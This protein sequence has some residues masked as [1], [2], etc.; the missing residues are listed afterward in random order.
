MYRIPRAELRA[1]LPLMLLSTTA[2]LA[3]SAPPDTVALEQITVAGERRGAAFG[4]NGGRMPNDPFVQGYTPK[5]TTTALKIPA[6]IQDIPVSVQ[7]V[8]QELIQD[9]GALTVRQAIDTVS[10]VTSSNAIPGSQSFRIR[11]FN[12]GFSNLR[13]GFRETSN[14]QDVQGIER[15]EVLK[16]PASVLYGGN[17]AAGGVVNIVT[18]TPVDLNFANAALTGGSF[19]LVRPTF[20]VNQDLTGDGRLAMRVTGAFERTDTYRDFAYGDSKFVNPSLRWR[21]T[22]QDEIIVRAQVL[23]SNFSYGPYQSPLS[24]TTLRLPYSFSFS[25]PN[26][27]D[28]HRNAER[29]SYDWI[30][31]FDDT[32]RFRSGFNA[33]AVNYDIGTDRFAVLRFNADG[34]TVSRTFVTGPQHLRDYDWQNEFSGTF[35]TGDIRHDWLAG[36]ETY[37]SFNSATSFQGTLPNL[38]IFAPVYGVTPSA[39]RLSASSDASFTNIA[40]YVQDFVTLTPQ[41]RLLLGG[42][43]DVTDTV[44]LNRL[45]NRTSANAADRFSPRLGITYEPVPTTALFANWANGFVPTTQ[46]TVSGATLPPSASE[47]FEVGV[48]Q[49]A[50]DGRVQATVALF[51]VTRTNV[52]TPDPTNA[53]FSIA[54]GEQQSRGVEVDIAG[55]I[56]PGWKGVAS[57]AYTFADVTKDNRLPVGDLLAGVARHAGQVWTTYEFLP[58]S[59]LDGFGIGAGV[60]AE[61]AREATLPNTFKLPGYVRL[62]AAAWYRFAIQGQPFRAQL[63]LQNITDRR[64]YDTDGANVLRPTVPFTVLASISTQF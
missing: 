45:T 1:A 30:H 25:D 17:L 27:R 37:W 38:N 62:D 40:G 28:S 60:R 41:I 20:D 19:G 55:E 61:T 8:P 29:I 35:Y 12:D 18:K 15:I 11:G 46:T 23:Q 58:G 22:A 59:L 4:A 16:G 56:L 63:N 52:P 36:V 44:N 34:R 57:Y 48:K 21:P 47:Q 42:R 51:Q 39:L 6:P 24:R 53:T 3:Q 13:D 7:V 33:S 43:Y 49:Q 10:G 14:Q 5:Q 9:R 31:K 54:S 26:L 64:I 50:F 32:L 2:V